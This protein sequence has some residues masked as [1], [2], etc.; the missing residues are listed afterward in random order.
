MQIN[1]DKATKI[2]ELYLGYLQSYNGLLFNHAAEQSK[3]AVDQV[4]TLPDGWIFKVVAE[5]ELRQQIRF[6]CVGKQGKPF[7]P[8]TH[9]EVDKAETIEEIRQL[10]DEWVAGFKQAGEDGV[11]I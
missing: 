8:G 5:D 9:V 1:L 6:I 11:E 4:R 2:A 7:R 10:G 3:I